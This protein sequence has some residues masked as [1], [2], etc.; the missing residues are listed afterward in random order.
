MEPDGNTQE[1][2]IFAIAES[3]LMQQR[4]VSVFFSTQLPGLNLEIADS[5]DL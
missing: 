3:H 5:I 2:Q 1:Y 4:E